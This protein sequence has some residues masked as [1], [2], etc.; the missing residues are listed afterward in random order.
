M[1]KNF[2]AVIRGSETKHGFWLPG[3]ETYLTMLR[4]ETK[5]AAVSIGHVLLILVLFF[6]LLHI[7]WI[8]F[9]VLFH[10]PAS[11]YQRQLTP[12]E[13][14]HFKKRLVYHGLQH[15]VSVVYDY[16]ENPYFIRDGRKCR[17]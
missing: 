14:S 2:S 15:T 6:L 1:R 3:L 9:D 17:F 4:Y 11:H 7:S 16:P 13:K 8:T 10:T 12:V 5:K